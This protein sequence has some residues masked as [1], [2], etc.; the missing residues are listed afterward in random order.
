MEDNKIPIEVQYRVIGLI[1]SGNMCFLNSAM[2]IIKCIGP[3]QYIVSQY[4]QGNCL[5]SI[6]QS[7]SNSRLLTPNN[8]FWNLVELYLGYDPRAIKQNCA[9]EFLR[10]FFANLDEE[11]Q[12]KYPK[13]PTDDANWLEA[14]NRNQSQVFNFQALGKSRLYDILGISIKSEARSKG[15]S[16]IT[17]Q[18]ELIIAIQ[19][20][21]TLSAGLEKYFNPVHL[22]SYQVDGI[23]TKCKSTI[24]ISAYTPYILFH[25]Q[26]FRV[27]NGKVYKLKKFMEY[28]KSLRIPNKCLTPSLRLSIENNTQLPPIYELKGIIEHHGGSANSGHYTAVVKNQQTWMHVDDNIVRP[29]SL[30]FVKNRNAYVLLYQQVNREFL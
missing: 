1:N 9:C 7:I 5:R 30:D 26:R 24:L 20:D 16:S 28:P 6:H 8:S 21:S 29:V 23:P 27:E 18:Q 3:L 10:F 13:I 15:T 14:G 19:L 22:E 12:D 17:Y 4:N 2:Q 11:L 25:I